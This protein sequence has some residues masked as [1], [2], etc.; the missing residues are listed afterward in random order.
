MIDHSKR[1][2]IKMFGLGK[3]K[4]IGKIHNAKVTLNNK[5][6]TFPLMVFQHFHPNCLVLGN[7]F[8]YFKVTIDYEL[9]LID[10]NQIDVVIKLILRKKYVNL[11]RLK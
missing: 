8:Y 9:K 7:F 3:S 2:Q 10:L 11:S 1:W 4:T 5:N 6:I